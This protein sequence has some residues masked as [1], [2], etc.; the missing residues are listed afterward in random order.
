MRIHVPKHISLRI[1]ITNKGD[2]NTYGYRPFLS[3]IK[4]NHI[5]QFFQPFNLTKAV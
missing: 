4:I 5:T 2:N 1:K 3:F